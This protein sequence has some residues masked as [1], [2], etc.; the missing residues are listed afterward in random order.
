[1]FQAWLDES[2]KSQPAEAGE[3]ACTG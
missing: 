1:M 2:K 3:V